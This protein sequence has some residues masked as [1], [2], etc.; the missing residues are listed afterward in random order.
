ML[1]LAAGP[2]A[3]ASPVSCGGAAML[4]AAQLLC[5]HTDPKQPTQLCTFSW[6]L[7]TSD[8]V[9]KVVEGSFLLPPGSSN[10]QVY[11]GSGFNNQL[12]QPIILCQASKRAQ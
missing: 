6:D 2:A 5:S 1:I 11:S 9:S 7:V 3:A 8:N 12:S 10:V 4:G